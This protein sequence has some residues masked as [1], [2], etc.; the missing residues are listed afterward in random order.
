[1]PSKGEIGTIFIILAGGMVTGCLIFL[2]N[3]DLFIRIVAG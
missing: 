1:M 3:P 2:S